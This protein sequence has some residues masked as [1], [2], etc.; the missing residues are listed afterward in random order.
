MMI[1]I[2]NFK[3]ILLYLLRIANESPTEVYSSVPISSLLEDNCLKNKS[4]YR[5]EKL[6]NAFRLLTET[7]RS[8]WINVVDQ[9]NRFSGMLFREDFRDILKGWSLNEVKLDLHSFG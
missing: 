5:G 3:D 6:V 4:V 1:S 7:H 8:L 2:I 9:N